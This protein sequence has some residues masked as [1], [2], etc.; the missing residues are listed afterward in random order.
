MEF[1]VNTMATV[2]LLLDLNDTL[3]KEI[4][5]LI[6]VREQ[7]LHSQPQIKHMHASGR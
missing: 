6:C 7:F 3:A 4:R 1:T 5:S 2:I